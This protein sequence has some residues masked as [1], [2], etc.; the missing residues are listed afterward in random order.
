MYMT[1]LYNFGTF[2]GENMYNCLREKTARNNSANHTGMRHG[3]ILYLI[4]MH[5]ILWGF[6]LYIFHYTFLLSYG[7]I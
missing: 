6:V 7:I 5:T 4:D 2:G 1:Y 3:H